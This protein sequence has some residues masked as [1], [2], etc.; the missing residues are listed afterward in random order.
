MLFSS[1]TYE[2]LGLR[3]STAVQNNWLKSRL[4]NFLPQLMARA[5]VDMWLIVC[6]EYNEDPVLM[7]LLPAPAMSARRRTILMFTR[8]ADGT[9]ERLSL[10][11]Y[12]WGNF[13][14]Q[15][16]NP[17]EERQWA[18][19]AR[20]VREKKPRTIALN[21]SATFAFADGL[22][23]TEFE[24]VADALGPDYLA[25]TVSGEPL[26]VGWLEYRLP[27]EIRAYGR[28]AEIG[29][30]IIAE[31]FS[32]RVIHPGITTPTDVVWWMRERMAALGLRPWF[33]PTVSVQAH[34]LRFDDPADERRPIQPSDLLHCDMGFHYLGLATDQQQHA[35]VLRP[36]ETA[37]PEGLQ[38][39]LGQGNRLQDIHLAQM[40]LGRTGNEVLTAVRQQ[41]LA[42]G[43]TPC[44]YSHP[45][46]YHG[47]AAG[48]TIGLWDQQGGVPGQG[49]YPLYDHTCYSI[50]LNVEV[51]VPEWD[52]QIVRIALEEDAVLT[53]GVMRWLHGRGTELHLIG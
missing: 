48:P 11:R 9:V 27:E 36:G 21:R 46:G 20:L 53:G 1:W 41:A 22:S 35:Y 29:H 44:V 14:Q 26:C 37:A 15:A 5:D 51:P 42:E 19:V 12:G 30:A 18:C 49:D 2:R 28:L 47:H 8:Q 23:Q 13:Y 25:R 3:E 10:D 38:A 45:L 7:S 40:Q 39:A 34:G 24:Q 4:D 6:R 31:A 32:S 16:W 17:D 50:E 43:L 33:Q 52:G